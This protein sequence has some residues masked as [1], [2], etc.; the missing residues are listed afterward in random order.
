MYTPN[1]ASNPSQ[2]VY[3]PT[4]SPNIPT[5]QDYLNG[6]YQRYFCKKINEISYLEID[7]NT[8]DKLRNKDS[9]I[10]WQLYT[11]FI[12]PWMLTGDLKEKIFQ[13]NK[14][15]VAVLTKQKQFVNFT[16]YLQDDYT[17]YYK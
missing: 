7:K 3:L 11:P 5:T 6:E 12:I 17:K 15:V 10:L 16:D 9:S 13:I 4:Y 14:K 2:E 8:Y 1:N